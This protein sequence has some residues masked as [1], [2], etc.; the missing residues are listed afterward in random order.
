MHPRAIHPA[1]MPQPHRVA[2]ISV[3]FSPATAQYPQRIKFVRRVGPGGVRA[4]SLAGRGLRMGV[5]GTTEDV[6]QD[7]GDCEERC[8]EYVDETNGSVEAVG[9][10]SREIYR[11]SRDGVI[12]TIEMCED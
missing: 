12:P 2:R 10:N 7:E 5:G 8:I 1:P 11:W 9:R 6:N 4:R 3:V